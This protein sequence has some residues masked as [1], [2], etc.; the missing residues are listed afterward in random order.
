MRRAC[1][2]YRVE[3][4]KWKGFLWVKLKERGHFVYLSVDTRIILKYILKVWNRI[5]T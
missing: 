2:A 1:S 4:C 3:K 5:R